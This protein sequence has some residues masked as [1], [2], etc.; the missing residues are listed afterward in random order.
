VNNGTSISADAYYDQTHDIGV[1]GPFSGRGFHYG[2]K[3][4]NLTGLTGNTLDEDFRFTLDFASGTAPQTYITVN[5]VPE[6]SQAIPTVIGLFA[7]ASLVW[8]RRRNFAGTRS[9]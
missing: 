3:T 8:C 5:P 6:P 9:K 2:Q 1:V 7:I 4:K